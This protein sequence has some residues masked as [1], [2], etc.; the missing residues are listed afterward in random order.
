MSEKVDEKVMEDVNKAK[1]KIREIMSLS[2]DERNEY[3]RNTILSIGYN[4]ELLRKMI[5]E[6]MKEYKVSKF[7]EIKSLGKISQVQL[8]MKIAKIVGKFLED[9]GKQQDTIVACFV[10]GMK[11]EFRDAY[12]ELIRR[13]YMFRE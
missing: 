4:L 1:M 8:G 11:P 7:E 12:F 9:M 3:V 2:E 10:Y 5:G 6:V 13:L